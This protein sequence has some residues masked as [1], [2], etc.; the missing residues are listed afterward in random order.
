[1]QAIVIP[2][3]RLTAFLSVS[4]YLLATSSLTAQQVERYTIPED[5]VAIYNLAGEVRMEPGSGDIS[6]QVTRGGADAAK[7]KV[8]RGER[9]GNETLRFVYPETRIQ[10]AGMSD[11]SSTQLK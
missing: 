10:Y 7:V 6:V 9:D 1:M 2:H 8:M 3:L 5:E 11:G 4:G